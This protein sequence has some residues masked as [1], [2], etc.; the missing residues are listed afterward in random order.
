MLGRMPSL[1][2]ASEYYLAAVSLIL[3]MAGMGATLTLQNFRDILLRPFPVALCVVLQFT[4]FP[5]LAALIGHAAG[6][7]PGIVVGLV[8]MNAVP[9]GSLTNVFTYLGKGNVTL[10][11]MITCASTLACFVAI[12]LIV[13]WLTPAEMP[14]DFQVPLDETVTHVVFFALLPMAAGMC[15]A[16]YWERC[17]DDF[18]KWA[19]RISLIPLTVL[20]VG[21][22][23]SGKVDISEYGWR[24]PVIVVAFIYGSLLFMRRLAMALGFDWADGFTMGIEVAVRNGKLGIALAAGLFPAGTNDHI[25]REVLFVALF[26][27]GATM[28]VALISVVRRLLIM[29]RDERRSAAQVETQ[30][31]IPSA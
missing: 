14:Q 6:F 12:P 8:L 21:A 5:V 30:A 15:F 27:S 24:F 2:A 23:S 16:R 9:S 17:K 31:E 4:L 18:A 3:A 1:Y 7:P 28:I 25:A 10:S 13:K 22:L 26:Y 11:I 19:V 29:R 20:I